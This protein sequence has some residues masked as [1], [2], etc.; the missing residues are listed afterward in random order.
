[1]GD[2]VVAPDGREWRV[3][4]R[5]L[6]RL[7]SDS[8]W[9]RF[10]RRTRRTRDMAG[11]L[12]DADPGCLDV[13]GEGF[14]FAIGVV[15]GAIVLIFIVIPLLVALVDVLVLLVLLVLS[16]LARIVLRRPWT[17]EAR[18]A[19]DEVRTWRVVGWRASGQ[20]RDEVAA[21]I[22]AGVDPGP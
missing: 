8:L 14:V 20:R 12:A 11:D 10:R 13:L 3:R 7:G 1:M 18:T 4:R 16:V 19:A 2:V 15:A 17:V 6:P 5:W 9:A 22:A 21:A